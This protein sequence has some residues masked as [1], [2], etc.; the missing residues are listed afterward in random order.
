MFFGIS[1]MLASG[2]FL[3]AWEEA[4]LAGKA[5]IVVLVIGSI[6]S[7]SII[8]TKIGTVR[9]AVRENR[10]FLRTFRT[11][12]LPLRLFREGLK[13]DASPTFAVYRAGCRELTF[14]LLGSP[15]LDETFSARLEMA[16]R[17]SPSQMNVVSSAMERA[18]GETA[19]KLEDKMIL[20]ATAVSGGPFLGLLGTVWG[21][22]DTFS[23][24]AASGKASLAVMAPGVAGALVT[25][26]MGL[27]VA[28]PS[29]FA[30]NFLVTHIRA[31]VVQ[32][33]NFSAELGSELSHRYVNHGNRSF[34][35]R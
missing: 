16:E 29:M 1:I 6:F 5:I 20:L 33:E 22:M 31:L 28:I 7:W 35:D 17:L 4:N 23:G 9:A 13:F 11:D 30:Y 34:S 18:V 14:Q 24:I 8:L 21:V 12:R 25:T 27:L 3:F 19:L 10:R 26:V 15:E 32:M 2:G